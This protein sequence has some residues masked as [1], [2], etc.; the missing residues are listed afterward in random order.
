MPNPTRAALLIV[1]LAA[2]LLAIADN[3][4]VTVTTRPLAELSFQ[5]RYSA[6]ATT[7]SLNDSRISA[8]TSGRL[9]RIPV[10]V[11]DTVATGALVAELDCTGAE[12][13]KRRSEATVEAVQARLTLAERQI[14]RSRS[15][16]KGQAISEEL[17]NQRESELNTARADLAASR[18]ALEQA[19]LERQRC[20]VTAPFAGLLVERLANEGEWVTP[21]QPLVRLLDSERL[22]VSAQV[23][24]DQAGT[25][26]QVDRVELLVGQQRYPL[27]LRHL[28]PLIDPKGRNREVRL[29]FTDGHALPGSSGRV[30]WLASQPH[31]PADIPVRRNGVLGVLLADQ[32]MA[33][34]HSLEGALEGQPTPVGSLPPDSEVIINGRQRLSDGDPILLG[35]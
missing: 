14:R 3:H 22:E 16:S 20:R 35:N 5:P 6:P 26:E 12:I 1:L 23:R 29:E 21:G 24:L 31:L 2:P 25:L 32:G 19:E 4:A 15:L 17:L 8:E 9:A 28:L 18:A 13:Q 10:R 27:Q 7:L 30:Q 11:G 34:F 33:R